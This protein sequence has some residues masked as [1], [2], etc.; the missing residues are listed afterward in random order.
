MHFYKKLFFFNVWL[1]LLYSKLFESEYYGY[2]SGINGYFD[3]EKKPKF[4]K[5]TS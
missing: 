2:L 1:I 3:D 4:G 5:N